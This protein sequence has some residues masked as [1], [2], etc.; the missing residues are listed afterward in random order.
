MLPFTQKILLD[1]AGEAVF[2]DG[3]LLYQKAGVREVEFESPLVKG[4]VGIG[5]R[6]I[7]SSFRV[8]PDG[9]VDNLCPCRDSTVRGIVCMH[10]V[11]L[12]LSLC[13]RAADPD[14][15]L[16]RR[17]ELR[18]AQRIAG[19]DRA[20]YLQHVTSDAAGAVPARLHLELG[21][22]WQAGWLAGAVPIACRVEAEGRTWL[23]D[24]A[25][26]NVRF[27]FPQ[28]DDGILY[29]LEDVS[30][31]PAAGRFT[32]SRADFSSLMALL[33][34]KEVR[35]EGAR[36]PLTVNAAK[37]GSNLL[38]ELDAETGELLLRIHTELPFL[39]PGDEPFYLP[40]RRIGWVFGAGNF[41]Q[42]ERLLPAPFHAIYER[43][44][45]VPRLAVLRFIRTELPVIAKTVPIQTDITLDLFTIAP[46]DAKFKLVVSGSPVSLSAVLCAEYGNLEL[47]AAKTDPN[48]SFA[49][50]DPSD[51]M[52]Y[53]VRNNAQ[54]SDAL[55]RLAPFGF[56]G[57]FG[58]Q[59][60]HIVDQREV[61]N[62][63]GSGLPALR[64]M[65]WKVDL[66]GKVEGLEAAAEH[67]VPVVKVNES[68]GSG[69]FEVDFAFE[70]GQG[71]GLAAADIQRALLKNE[72]FVERNGK[73]IL[74]DAGAINSM[75]E[76]F[77]D[78][79]VGEGGRPGSFRM[80]EIYSA[81]V[82][83]SLDA[84]DGIDV[85]A[86]PVWLRKASQQNRS[87][88]TEQVEPPEHLA[89][90]LRPYQ[91]DG[92]NWLRFL[93]QNGF[94]GILAD[95]MGLGKTLQTLAWLAIERVQ[96]PARNKPAL[97]V[98]PTSLVENW[99]EE[100]RKFVPDCR[101]LNVTGSGR[102]DK[103]DSLASHDLVVTSYALLRR[104]IEQ[105]T[106][107]EFSVIVLDEAQ[108]IKNRSTQNSISAKKLR[109]LHRLV[110]TGTPIENSVSDLWSIMDF[111]MPG[112]M[113]RHE[114]FRQNYEL[115]ITRGG[116]DGEFAQM[117]LRRKLQPFL[118]RRLKQD[119]AKD[120]PPK[121]QKVAS[122]MLTSDQYAVYRELV[123][124]SRRRLTDMVAKIGFQKA[125]MEV[126]KTLM[127][128][129]QTCCHLE[130]LKL[131]GLASK[132]PSGKLDMFLELMNEAMDGGHR[133][134]VFSQFVGMLTILRRELEQQGIR[135]CYL[136]G[137]TKDRLAIVQSFNTDR[138]IP[139]F[140]ISLKAGGT[141]LNLTGADM[142][143]HFDPWWNP[144]VEDQASDRAHRIGQKRT[145]YC[146]KLITKGTVEEKVLALQEKKR[147]I[148]NAALASDEQVM[149]KMTWEDV[150]EL[151]TL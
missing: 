39:K 92:F 5:D 147:L 151:L 63:L 119:V 100:A 35:L 51:L 24:E 69:W 62:F 132:A 23:L 133:M 25:P 58:D 71:Q 113:G 10:V 108:H 142:V 84:L 61:L 60:S 29:L 12:G 2:R 128:L 120:L 32:L 106:Q 36:E 1:W 117:K 64:R 30:E 149:G 148:I 93:E 34:G 105:Y 150:Q 94:A 15:E 16:K 95:E 4:V 96:E 89:S 109:A 75:N 33:P 46:A 107:Y 87:L 44:V 74:L 9:F 8:T 41:W 114:A 131:E 48:G 123:E 72:Y 65:G 146:V 112:Y 77:S 70:D 31:G 17:E 27:A 111:L 54:E 136:D 81:Y 47:V 18:R 13:R 59:L 85:E 130:L 118:L 99:I 127:R 67:A 134:L 80:P 53:L 110:L 52:R 57:A 11:A 6:T 139:V 143:V 45:F 121:I 83:S 42:L 66:K 43:P 28:K 124:S 137:S 122:C 126:F 145:V 91:K 19:I 140:L 141:G 20:Q 144:A 21:A 102:H 115:P 101:T 38:M 40:D 138:D 37:I 73:T 125:R 104:D 3:M 26:R 78:C 55:R 97:V 79:S 129:R 82:K 56:I 98:C 14:R 22:S 76:V 86:A 90:I 49:L 88:K 103:W 116:A 50:P 68:G 7:R 135:Y